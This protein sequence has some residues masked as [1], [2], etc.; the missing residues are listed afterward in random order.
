MD[1]SSLYYAITVFLFNCNFNFFFKFGGW[2]D[3]MAF[4]FHCR[5]LI[6]QMS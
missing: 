2:W 6:C 3:S 1:G 5:G 4:V